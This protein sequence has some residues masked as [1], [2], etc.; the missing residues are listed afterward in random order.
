M[1]KV[2]KT[3]AP[4]LI[5]AFLLISIIPGSSKTALAQESAYPIF[6]MPI[7]YI[8]YTI[9]PVDGVL[10]AKIDGVYPLFFHG[11]MPQSLQ[12]VYPT[13]PETT[14]IT[15]KQD[16]QTLTYTTLSNS[17]PSTL[18]HTAIGDW[19][20]ILSTIRITDESFTLKIHYEHP[21][22][23]VNGSAIFLYDLNI[24]P[25]LSASSNS[26]TAYFLIRIEANTS[27]VS[28]FTTETDTK[29]TPIDYTISNENEAKVVSI[30]LHSSYQKPAGDLVI[31]LS[32]DNIPE[33][34]NWLLLMTIISLF[35]IV[36]QLTK[37]K[38]R[39]LERN[40]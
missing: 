33:N 3:L 20:M 9:I 6:T 17:D 12:I 5:V 23:A 22:Q 28:A 31:L 37:V 18:H 19:Q 40:C 21:L 39:K 1:L 32:G 35:T 25:Y 14:N 13:P 27:I 26:S 7:E 8:N 11:E 30:V 34:S 15:L 38:R 36:L 24:S 4:M 10:W 2:E 16:N 29:W